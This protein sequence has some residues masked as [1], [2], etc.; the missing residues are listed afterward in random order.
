MDILSI[1]AKQIP[2]LSYFK[3]FDSFFQ[4]KD[5]LLKYLFLLFALPLNY[6]E[7]E[8]SFTYS[9]LEIVL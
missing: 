2:A 9:S 6:K 8:L 3:I 1:H 5:M 7:K 4:E